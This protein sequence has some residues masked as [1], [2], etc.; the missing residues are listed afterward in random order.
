MSNHTPGPW[1]F[2]GISYIWSDMTEGKMIAQVR[3][4]GW[5][6]KK[7]E[8]A[9]IAEQEANGRIL[10]AAPEMYDELEVATKRPKE[11]LDMME[12]EGFV[13]DNLDDR[14]QKLAFTLYTTI[15]DASGKAE[16]VL[17]KANSSEAQG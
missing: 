8:E 5:L 7:G 9:G 16:A 12:R 15:V 14:W 2:D 1:E 17:A 11:A 3:G 6:Q 13:F 10:A 4:W